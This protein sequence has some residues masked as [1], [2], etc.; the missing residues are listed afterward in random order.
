MSDTDTTQT[1][2]TTSHL[3]QTT[4]YSFNQNY[5]SAKEKEQKKTLSGS[6]GN[7]DCPDSET[8]LLKFFLLKGLPLERGI[9]GNCENGVCNCK[10]KP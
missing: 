10:V 5:I 9:M 3:S 8:H 6:V 1:P 7:G 2:D 4:Q